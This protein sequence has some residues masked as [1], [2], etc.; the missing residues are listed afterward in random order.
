MNKFLVVFFI[1]IITKTGAT[2]QPLETETTRL[3]KQ[4][5][6][7]FS[8]N[9]EYQTSKEGIETAIPFELSY[10]I[11]DVLL[12]LVEPVIGTSIRPI[13]GRHARGPGDL[14]T[15]LIYR[16]SEERED[17]PSFAVAAEVKIPIAKDN[18]IGTGKT[19][20][21]TYLIA[22]KEFGK[23]DTHVNLIYTMVGSPVGITL[24]NTISGSIAAEYHLNPHFDFVG[25]FFASTSSLPDA[26]EG[27]VSTSKESIV[28]PEAGGGEIFGTL[29]ARY[30]FSS[31]V[32]ATFG[33]GYD[34]KN[35]VLF[36]PGLI[37]KF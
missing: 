25:E 1:L 28:V 19:D 15:T 31:N 14:E 26:T 30:Y 21:A 12:L 33:L 9:Y 29:G 23:W 10:G 17:I 20:F 35:A 3:L 16:F 8:G 36:R 32:V 27:A 11:S 6:F 18:L 4:G 22:S 2:G 24:S 7:E 34:S 37:V 5:H 13:F